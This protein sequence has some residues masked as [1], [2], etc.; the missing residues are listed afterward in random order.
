MIANKYI[1]ETKVGEGKFGQVFRGFYWKRSANQG[2][3][4]ATTRGVDV[5]TNL[6]VQVAIK[7]EG[8]NTI[9]KTLRHEATL[10]HYLYERGCRKTP[11]V[12]WYGI[13][14]QNPAL[15]MPYY[16][17][18]LEYYVEHI[19]SNDHGGG[20]MINK[21]FRQMIEI[22]ETIHSHYVIHRDI[23]PANFM[24]R[25][26]TGEIVL[27]DFGLATVFVDEN[28]R[29][30]PPP[31][32]PKTTIIGTPKYISYN[33]HMGEEPSRRDDLISVGYVLL[34]MILRSLG[35]RL[36]WE[37]NGSGVERAKHKSWTSIEKYVDSGS[38][39]YKYLKEVYSLKY[40]EDPKYQEYMGLS[41]K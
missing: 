8:S 21:W 20:K 32:E 29:H 36:P 1:I 11:I 30:F 5:A 41:N 18:S 24:L 2:V 34:W 9:L 35:K 27:I 12:Y 33:I 3:D 7:I 22:L 16:E 13:V 28:N 15:I 31:M 40:S 23:K 6:K 17:M 4:V 19:D 38:N 39:V 25:V 26:A 37:K 14:D 10:L